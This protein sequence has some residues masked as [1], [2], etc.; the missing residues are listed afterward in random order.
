MPKR[1]YNL[2]YRLCDPQ[3]IT[4]GYHLAQKGKS[5]RTDIKAFTSNLNRNLIDIWSDLDSLRYVHGKYRT[6]I[7]QQTKR[8]VIN[9][10]PFRDRV[11]HH[12]FINVIKP[13]WESVYIDNTYACRKGYGIH[14]CLTD[15]VS[16][17]RDAEATGYVLQID[18][19]QYYDNIDHDVL[20]AIERKRIADDDFM[21]ISDRITNSFAPGIPKGN[22]TSQYKA[23]LYLSYF[24][25]YVK[26]KLKV[27][28]YFRY[29]DDMVFFAS[30]KSE[31]RHVYEQIEKYL[32]ENLKLTIKS[33]WQIY[34][35]D[36][37]PLDFV[38]YKTDH[39]GVLLRKNILKNYYRKLDHLKTKYDIIDQDNIKHNLSS[40]WGWLGYCSEY[41]FENVIKQ[42]LNAK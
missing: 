42:S 33:N 34:P 22:Y 10:A 7:V 37:R 3:N 17:L 2:H 9:I 20:K 30:T 6:M 24:D 12:C 29:M 28:Y 38:G 5:N 40:Y 23:N 25:H 32:R 21:L 31:L 16:C 41:H 26:E 18:I 13:T 14:K 15:V 1:L 11:V 8:R 4:L 35:I 19:K 36:S 27:K 39:N